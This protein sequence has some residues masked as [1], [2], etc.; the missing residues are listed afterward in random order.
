V[1]KAAAAAA[2][3]PLHVLAERTELLGVEAAGGSTRIE[4]ISSAWGR[5]VLE[6]PLPGAHQVENAS[7]AAELLGLLPDGLRPA[8]ADLQA[9]FRSVRWPG[10]L[11]IEHRSGTTWVFDVAHNPAGVSALV[12]ALRTLDLP[13]PRILL[14]SM[15]ADKDWREMLPPLV[16]QSDAVILTNPDSAPSSRVWNPAQVA[17]WLERRPGN[18]PV[19]VIPS[20]TAA[21]GRAATLA[22]HGTVVV[23]GSFHTVGDAM[24]VLGI[25]SV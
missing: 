23:T 13:G 4:I 7:L 1:L 15:L 16:E 6:I 20:L 11:Q 5:I 10:R 12:E 25:P 2:G 14:V 8:G 22:P 3:A 17:E 19:R 9:G 21:A 18:P 24:A